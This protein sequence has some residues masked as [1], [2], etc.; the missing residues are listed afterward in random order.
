MAIASL[1]LKIGILAFIFWVLAAVIAIMGLIASLLYRGKEY[2]GEK[3]TWIRVGSVGLAVI[4]LAP[5]WVAIW[6]INQ[7]QHVN[8]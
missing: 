4:A 5:V 7:L 3:L 1:F 6:A 8:W 2:Q